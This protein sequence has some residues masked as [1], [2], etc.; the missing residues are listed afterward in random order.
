MTLSVEIPQSLKVRVT[1]VAPFA[2][3]VPSAGSFWNEML[4]QVAVSAAP[5]LARG[6]K[7]PPA[8]P[9][10]SI[11]HRPCTH[12]FSFCSPKDSTGLS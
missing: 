7:Y 1:I 2:H 10:L 3:G 6:W 5:V 8:R 12:S 11:P 9:S 4:D